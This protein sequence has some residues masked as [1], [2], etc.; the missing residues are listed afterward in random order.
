MP[1]GLPGG[2]QVRFGAFEFDAH[3]LELRRAG[4]P[5]ALAPQPAQ[6]L[7]AL[8]ARAGDVVSREE[9]RSELWSHDTFVD[10]E[11]GLNYCLGR[12]RAVLGDD[13]R[14]P[15]YIETLPRRGY[16]FVAEIERLGMR[17]RTLA[18]LPFDNIGGDPGEEF[19]ADGVADGLITELGKVA[20]LRVISRQSVLAF[21]GS[22]LHMSD[23][24]QR[25]KADTV[26]EGSVLQRG[27][28][29]RITAQLIE[30]EPERHLWAESYDGDPRDFMDLLVRVARAV[31]RAI[32]VILAPEDEARLANAAR[33]PF[34]PEAQTAYLKAR[35]HLGK[36]SGI[37][38][39][40]GLKLLHEA[41]AIDPSHAPA[42]ASLGACLALLGY[43]GHAP[44]RLVYPQA[45]A[46]TMK[47]VELDPFSSAAH[48]NLGFLRMVYDWDF[49]AADACFRRALETGPNN[50]DALLTHAMFLLWIRDDKKRALVET[51]TALA[52]DPVSPFTNSMVLWL[53]LM[54]AE[55]DQ[56]VELAERTLEMYPDAHQAVTG[57]GWA[58]VQ[59]G[60]FS[61]AIALFERAAAASPDPITVS[62]LGHVYGLAG[63]T[64]DARGILDKLTQADPAGHSCVKSIIS[65]LAGLG[66]VDRAFEWIDRGIAD[67]D[68]GVL[69]ARA[70]P[71]FWPLMSDP[72]FEEACRRMGLSARE[73]LGTSVP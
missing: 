15:A 29:L 17:P 1:N 58:R 2:E 47:A 40:K 66:E 55:I 31:A 39:E 62:F 27:D 4:R 50:G 38:F 43:N 28:R 60:R 36:W 30:V 34:R 12:L 21:K 13:A 57:L 59:Q 26:L 71:P 8:I 52:L 5:L 51:R 41:I 42:H 6:L 23:I 19:L 67:R 22:T 70:S 20:G 37:E 18:V 14:K 69:S 45:K 46:M 7:R 48:T 24:A 9:L 72:R 73:A 32:C 3:S 61:E 44:W 35:F 25:L 33:T 63:R 64:G 49:E 56:V 11:S 68:G 54:A 65:V 10:F 53:M 16:R